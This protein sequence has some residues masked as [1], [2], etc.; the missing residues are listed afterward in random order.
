[1]IMALNSKERKEEIA[2][3]PVCISRFIP[4]ATEFSGLAQIDPSILVSQ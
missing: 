2:N 1:M 3:F 4:I